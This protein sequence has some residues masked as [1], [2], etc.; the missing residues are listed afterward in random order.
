MEQWAGTFGYLLIFFA[1]IYFMMIR[2]QQ[3]QQKQRR[4][5]LSKLRTNDHIVTIGGVHGRITRL[6]EDRLSLR[7]ADKVEVELEKSAVA[8]VVNPSKDDKDDSKGD[9]SE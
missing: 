4:E 9:K 1:I 3:K 7:I 2:P 5:M 8:H 6:K